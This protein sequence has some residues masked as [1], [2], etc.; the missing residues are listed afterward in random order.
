[1]ALSLTD[2]DRLWYVGDV[3]SLPAVC[4][5]G[6]AAWPVSLVD[7]STSC[8]VAADRSQWSSRSASR[9]ERLWPLDDCD[10]SGQTSPWHSHHPTRLSDTDRQTDNTIARQ[11]HVCTAHTSVNYIVA[12]Q[13]SPAITDKPTRRE[14][15][16]KLLQFNVPT[17]FSL[18]ILAYLHAFNCYCVRN[19]W[20][21]LKIQT[22]GVQG[23]PRSSIL[24]P[25][26]SPYVTCY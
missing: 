26:E 15:L 10:R 19:P 21:S 17:T 3:T 14:S 5:W 23:H 16:P 6:P 1:M 25:I 12:K 8:W 2:I 24:V 20:N 13:E 9:R 18:T 7:L 11:C 22:Y 4:S